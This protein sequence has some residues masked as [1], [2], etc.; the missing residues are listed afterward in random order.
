MKLTVALILFS[1]CF[2]AGAANAAD[3]CGVG[4][5]AAVNGG[6]VVNGWEV[7]AVAWNEC[8]PEHTPC[9]PA[10]N[11]MSGAGTPG[12]AFPPIE[13]ATDPQRADSLRRQSRPSTA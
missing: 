8:L 5:H 10:R 12:R 3:G 4:C 13:A 7:G 2:G 9:R 1:T 6:C 11:A